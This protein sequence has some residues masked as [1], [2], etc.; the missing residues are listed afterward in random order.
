MAAGD[1]T[2]TGHATDGSEHS[3]GH[4][5]DWLDPEGLK[6]I[7]RK[8]QTEEFDDP[9]THKRMKRTKYLVMAEITRKSTICI[10]CRTEGCLERLRINTQEIKDQPIRQSPCMIVLSRP[11]YRCT[12]CG[13]L[14]SEL[15][16]HPD[17]NRNVTDRLRNQVWGDSFRKSHS[18][19]SDETGLDERTIHDI[20]RDG[21][22][23][24]DKTRQINLPTHLYFDDINLS[25]KKRYSGFD[26]NV[27]I[28]EQTRAACGDGERRVPIEIFE[29]CD[30]EL[31][32]MFFAQ[33][34][35]EQLDRVEYFSMDMSEFFESVGI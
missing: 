34:T 6:M 35:R 23:A 10:F 4:L 24:L 28:K 18:L 2:D 14:W 30:I 17:G 7:D 8:T 15:I 16:P 29:K 21:F 27:P 32:T 25:A 31:I 33:F 12:V 1:G 19:I 13:G 26:P 3:S 22:T 20:V 11:Y 5:P 9:K